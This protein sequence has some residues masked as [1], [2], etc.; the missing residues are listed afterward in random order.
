MSN[1][2]PHQNRYV[3]SKLLPTHYYRHHHEFGIP[4]KRY[5]LNFDEHEESGYYIDFNQ[6]HLVYAVPCT[7]IT[8]SKKYNRDDLKNE[9]ID[10]TAETRETVGTTAARYHNNTHSRHYPHC[11]HSSHVQGFD[12]LTIAKLM[13]YE[14]QL[15]D[16]TPERLRVL[17]ENFACPRRDTVVFEHVWMEQHKFLSM[18]FKVHKKPLLDYCLFRFP[19]PPVCP[20]PVPPTPTEPPYVISVVPTQYYVDPETCAVSVD[21]LVTFNE[22]VEKSSDTYTEIFSVTNPDVWDETKR[23]QTIISVTKDEGYQSIWTVRTTIDEAFNQ[24]LEQIDVMIHL[25]KVI[26]ESG[27]PGEMD[28]MFHIDLEEAF[29]QR[30]SMVYE[31]VVKDLVN[32]TTTVYIAFAK[33][34]SQVEETVYLSGSLDAVK[35]KFKLDAWSPKNNGTNIDLE[36]TTI[37]LNVQH[38]GHNCIEVIYPQAINRT[39]PQAEG[40]IDT[41]FNVYYTLYGF[42]F[43]TADNYYNLEEGAEIQSSIF[44]KV[45]EHYEFVNVAAQEGYL[46]TLR[47]LMPANI[48]DTIWV[49]LDGAEYHLY[50]DYDTPAI[51]AT[52]YSVGAYDSELGG[53]WVSYTFPEF[54]EDVK[55]SFDIFGN[56]LGANPSG[57]YNAS[58]YAIHPEDPPVPTHGPVL[59][60]TTQETRT[61]DYP[62]VARFVFDQDVEY[63]NTGNI[64]ISPV[65][66]VDMTTYTDDMSLAEFEAYVQSFVTYASPNTLDACFSNSLDANLAKEFMVDNQTLPAGTIRSYLETSNPMDI[67][68][69]LIGL[70]N[71]LDYVDM[72]DLHGDNG[73]AVPIFVEYLTTIAT[74]NNISLTDITTD[75]TYKTILNSALWAFSDLV[76]YF[77]NN[78]HA[79]DT[80]LQ[81]E[82]NDIYNDVPGQLPADDVTLV[83]QIINT[84]ANNY[85]VTVSDLLTDTTKAQMLHETINHCIKPFALYSI[86]KDFSETSEYT[87]IE[88]IINDTHSGT[89]NLVPVYINDQ[90]F[91]YYGRLPESGSDELVASLNSNWDPTKPSRVIFQ[92]NAVR[93]PETGFIN[94]EIVTYLPAWQ[95]P[96]PQAPAI[97]DVSGYHNGSASP[98]EYW[99]VVDFD[100]PIQILDSP[101]S[102]LTDGVNE[103]NEMSYA[104]TNDD[105]RLI[106]YYDTP[107]PDW[108]A[109]AASLD[110]T[111]LPYTIADKDDASLI[112]PDQTEEGITITD[113][114]PQE[115][116]ITGSAYTYDA[117][118]QHPYVTR[119]TLDNDA[120]TSSQVV[121]ITDGVNTAYPATTYVSTDP[122]TNDVYYVAEFDV[123]Q[124]TDWIAAGAGNL[125]INVPANAFVS[126]DGIPNTAYTDTNIGFQNI[127][128]TE[129]VQFYDGF[130]GSRF[131]TTF[132]TH[133]STVS[134]EPIPTH[135]GYDFDNYYTDSS[136]T[137]LF[138]FTQP[139]TG[140][141]QVWYH[142]V[143]HVPVPVQ[144][145]N[146]TPKSGGSSAYPINIHSFGNN[147]SHLYLYL[148]YDTKIENGHSYIK[149][150]SDSKLR[151]DGP[152]AYFGYRINPVKITVRG[153]ECINKNIYNTST[154]WEESFS[155]NWIDLGTAPSSGNA[156]INV[157]AS[158]AAVGDYPGFTFNQ[159]YNGQIAYLS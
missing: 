107:S 94:N 68:N 27:T 20:G 46:D 120:L 80:E 32:N 2:Y 18:Y 117:S 6:T 23:A 63:V 157:Y 8:F 73:D 87:Q 147:N 14:M 34:G 92:T 67:K 83:K 138:D 51:K 82:L 15:H 140:P 1:H 149:F 49:Y 159:N 101:I 79:V 5:P 100:K 127:S 10:T 70:F 21:L 124:G 58:F 44:A 115:A 9:T 45:I 33:L 81:S 95:G 128:P 74:A 59:N 25:P 121:S 71:T 16:V 130:D 153:V 122:Q 31:D 145:T 105:T 141:T 96:T 88:N 50:N 28:A 62:Y 156:T 154:N 24:S 123:P 35:E 158:S 77:A 13:D 30:I 12:V 93:N 126:L 29:N 76:T 61:G 42:V 19:E 53:F 43:K 56:T 39:Y 37:N 133:G 137:T 148:K 150:T 40:E 142:Y 57:Y 129:E 89:V 139:I 38:N 66:N 55:Y 131:M 48:D 109:D 69:Y 98:A 112:V 91:D 108:I 103:A 152:S 134:P 111:I 119:F 54:A 155:T 113:V 90:S 65:T 3:P 75:P 110:L 99:F 41:S 146:Q 104:L 7:D 85:T 64:F 78:E 106:L 144:P 102:A 11:A 118:M 22:P 4:F 125:T 132:V 36:P 135:S 143:Q 136:Y 114:T 26:N 97:T 17:F 47:V 116:H 86:L 151:C 84:I 60:T 52:S 72:F